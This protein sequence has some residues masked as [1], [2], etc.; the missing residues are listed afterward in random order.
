MCFRKKK[1]HEEII[2]SEYKVGDLVRFPY[3]GDLFIG[4]VYSVKKDENG[5][6]FYTIQVG[7]ECPSF[8]TNYPSEKV[9]HKKK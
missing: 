6:I 5:N 8:V 3:R 7:G 9:V 1:R 2:D 4:H